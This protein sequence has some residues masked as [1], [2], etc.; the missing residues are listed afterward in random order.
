PEGGDA[1]G[2]GPSVVVETCAAVDEEDPG[3]G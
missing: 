2:L 1:F 3:T